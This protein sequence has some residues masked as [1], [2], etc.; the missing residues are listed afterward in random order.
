MLKYAAGFSFQFG[1]H[2][3][4]SIFIMW[5]KK[6]FISIY[7]YCNLQNFSLALLFNKNDLQHQFSDRRI[8]EYSRKF[9]WSR[10][11][12]HVKIRTFTKG[13]SIYYLRKIFRKTNIY[14][15]ICKRV[16][17]YQEVNV[18]FSENFVNVLNGWC[19]T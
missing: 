11:K 5:L 10:D 15:L 16:S 14:L 19:L 4:Q 9:W 17:A 2:D 13:S 3:L 12:I 8:A 7:S 6:K 1:F 18:S